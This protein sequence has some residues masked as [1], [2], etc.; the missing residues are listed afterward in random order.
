LGT[1]GSGDAGSPSNPPF[2]SIRRESDTPADKEK[3]DEKEKTVERA[4]AAEVLKKL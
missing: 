2:P 4:I 3:W 1:A